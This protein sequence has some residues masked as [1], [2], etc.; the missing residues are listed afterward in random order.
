MSS[1]DK[2]LNPFEIAKRQLD[3]ESLLLASG[4]SM[5]IPGITNSYMDY[6]GQT[7]AIYR[8]YLYH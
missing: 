7:I 4:V 1:E 3:I 8:K 5:S 2:T 6:D